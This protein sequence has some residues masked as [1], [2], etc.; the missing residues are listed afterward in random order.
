MCFFY[1][2][3]FIQYF[4]KNILKNRAWSLNRDITFVCVRYDPDLGTCDVREMGTAIKEVLLAKC[5]EEDHQ[6]PAAKRTKGQPIGDSVIL[7]DFD[8]HGMTEGGA[9]LGHVSFWYSSSTNDGYFGDF[10]TPFVL[11]TNKALNLHE[12]AASFAAI[13]F[14]LSEDLFEDRGIY[15]GFSPYYRSFEGGGA[16]I[17]GL[18]AFQGRIIPES[19]TV[20]TFGKTLEWSPL[21]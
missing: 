13:S 12:P 7:T 6:A 3:Q 8:L 11:D 2:S 14:P 4:N 5:R 16:D 20:H 10:S 17:S 21:R 18:V 9:V 1:K 15:A 19:L